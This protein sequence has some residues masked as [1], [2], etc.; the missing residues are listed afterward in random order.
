MFYRESNH[1]TKNKKDMTL[2]NTPKS[3]LNHYFKICIQFCLSVTID[4]DVSFLITVCTRKNC[5]GPVRKAS[6]ELIE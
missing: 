5:R 3:P 6:R 4:D 2:Y 1:E